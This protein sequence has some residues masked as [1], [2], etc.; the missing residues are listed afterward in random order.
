MPKWF[1]SALRTS[2]QPPKLLK[3]ILQ[4]EE[5]DQEDVRILSGHIVFDRMTNGF[6][7]IDVTKGEDQL[8]FEY[9]VERFVSILS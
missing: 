3:S 7:H 1:L 6:M 5:F 2:K 9:D 4:E 8:S